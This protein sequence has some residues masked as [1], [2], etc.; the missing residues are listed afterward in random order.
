M[1]RTADY[2]I[3]GF[4]YQFIITLNKLLKCSD[5][6]EIVVEGIIEDIDIVM[7]S[8]IE[9]V[10]CK[11][12]EAKNKFTLSSI[13]KPILQMMINFDKN[14][15]AKIKYRL[16]AHFPNETVGTIKKLSSKDIEEVLNSSSKELTKLIDQLSAF[17]QIEEFLNVFEIEF[18][19]S[20][21]DSQR[22]VIVE[23]SQEGFSTEDVEEIFYPNAIHAIAE[24]SINHDENAR[25]ITKESF[26]N[27]LR[28]KKTTAINRWTKEL[29]S[30]QKLLKRRR[31]Q[32]HVNLNLN[33]R[34]R[35]LILDGTY[36]NDFELIA[37]KLIEDFINKYNSKP[38][39]NVCPTFCLKTTEDSLNKI[40]K[41]L[42]KRSV[43]IE[44]GFIAG[45]FDVKRFLRE[46]IKLSRDNRQEFNLRMCNFELD[47]LA[48]VNN[49]TFDDIFLVSDQDLLAF[50]G[51]ELS[52]VEKLATPQVNEI[53][54]LL[55]L[56]KSL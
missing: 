37:S 16:H 56:N 47:F 28:K 36:I 43:N 53:S 44:R 40:W 25:K 10:Q 15:S 9:A 21:G 5:D 48:I 33:S 26:L 6:T 34:N 54:Y 46:P 32:L 18:G 20:Y 14:P 22:S 49:A 35:C 52:I 38:R 41:I 39:L 3:Q 19:A 29:E 30:F 17:H 12:H 42:N 55:S 11:Y 23:L 50:I 1:A 8:G 27:G 31:D 2:S 24:I 45:E 4:I 51:I 13:Y 7:P